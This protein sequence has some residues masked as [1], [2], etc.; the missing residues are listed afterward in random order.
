MRSWSRAEVVE[1]RIVGITF[2]NKEACL[3]ARAEHRARRGLRKNIK[4]IG[5]CIALALAHGGVCRVG[6]SFGLCASGFPSAERSLDVE[7]RT[8]QLGIHIRCT[9]IDK[10]AYPTTILAKRYDHLLHREKGFTTVA[11]HRNL[12]YLFDPAKLA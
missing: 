11:D 12:T 3:G 4:N 10:E 5:A 6:D 1:S 7:S 9:G 2:T 8:M